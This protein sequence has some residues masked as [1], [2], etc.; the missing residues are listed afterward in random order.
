MFNK[1][2]IAIIHYSGPP[3]IAGVENLIKEHARAFRFYK[4]SVFI[5]VG[6]GEEFRKDIPMKIFK[7]FS[8]HNSLVLK[9][10]EEYEKGIIS[11]NFYQLEKRI[12]EK[13]KDY[14]LQE[15]IDTCIV[16]NIMTM[17]Y[18]LPLTSALARLANDL[19]SIRFI[20]WTHD[21]TFGDNYYK[22]SNLS[23]CKRYPWSLIREPQKNF[24]YV[25]ISKFRRNQ[26]KKVFKKQKFKV[27]LIPNFI[28]FTKF[29]AFDLQIRRLIEETHI[30]EADLIGLAPI[31][32]V[33]RKNLELLILIVKELIKKGINLKFI[34]TAPLDFQL[35]QA[36]DYLN[37][38][39]KKI[40]ELGLE[41]HIIILSQYK[42]KDGTKFNL[43]KLNPSNLYILSDF[44]LLTS[45]I[46]GCGL[47]LLEASLAKI[48]IFCSNIPTFREI[49]K[50]LVYY[51]DLKDKPKKIAERIISY[52]KKSRRY[53]FS[54]RIRKEYFFRK[55]FE[56]QIIPFITGMKV[57]F[58]VMGM[59]EYAQAQSF[60]R[61]VLLNKGRV[62]F[63]TPFDN[64]YKVIKLD[65]PAKK[66]ANPKLLK[67]S[68]EKEGGDLLVL[69]NSKTTLPYLKQRPKNIKYIISLD[70]NWLFGQ[71]NK[72]KVRKWIDKYIVVM[73]HKIFKYGLKNHGGHYQIDDYY[74]KK[75]YTPGFIP[76]GFS[77]FKRDKEEFLKENRIEARYKIFAYF[78]KGLTYKKYGQHYF[79]KI[80]PVLN[81]LNKELNFNLI[82]FGPT[83]LKRYKYPWMKYV[84]WRGERYY[85]VAI[86][87]S[88]LVIQH[89]GL[90]T[91]PKV[92]R[93]NKPV[94]CFT[95]NKPL[96]KI[97]HSPYYEIN[98]FAR[99][100][101][102]EQLTLSCTEDEI[103]ELIKEFLTGKDNGLKKILKMKKAQRL[104]YQSGVNNLYNY[105]QKQLYFSE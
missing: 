22:N 91:L 66:I 37:S 47:P 69:C 53:K 104:I 87:I 50:D 64:F 48:P 67:E 62:F 38:I 57:I 27:K 71:I 98:T 40:K 18:N 59:G 14:L 26:L 93:Q 8:P 45:K 95:P 34:I 24:E 105:I 101:L 81:S 97:T 85:E 58:V 72:Y 86:S 84:D 79:K 80:L 90:G 5:I 4:L 33:K 39:I 103:K 78:G 54:Y 20:A 6:A 35:P 17:H 25:A 3:I 82:I 102:C 68:I 10:R 61:T 28:D 94:I 46:E 15:K 70:S 65:F 83:F 41:S 7:D 56:E 75:I 100:N 55:V 99:L 36:H 2:K 63:F 21:I 96:R 60:A 13:L 77:I 11:N 52:C 42:F 32:A 73:P 23:I 43:P 29:F 74:L 19:P 16:H 31:R 92:I 49:G 44:V 9:V 30:E 89:H 88:D 12:Y 1:P 51:F 76:A